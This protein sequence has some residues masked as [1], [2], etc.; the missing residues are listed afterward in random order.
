MSDASNPRR[1]LWE[2]WRDPFVAA[3][4]EH[5]RRGWFDSYEYADRPGMAGAYQGPCL[6]GPAGIV[7]LN[8]L[9]SPSK[10]F[11]LWV[12]HT[13]FDID[14]SSFDRMKVVP[15]VEVLKVWTRYRFWL[16][17]AKAFE[18]TRVKRDVL[19][20]ASPPAPP[21]RDPL[22]GLKGTLASRHRYWAIVRREDGKYDVAGGDSREE[23]EGKVRLLGGRP[24]GVVTSWDGGK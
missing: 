5:R 1:I 14:Q 12:G 18:E 22:A 7:P 23:V 24:L 11:N 3:V 10:N 19:A 17:V 15:G 2:R 4:E 8:E 6:F 13:S 20:A 21:A 9:N 16:G